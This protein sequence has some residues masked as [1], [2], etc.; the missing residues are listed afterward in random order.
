[1]ASP[2]DEILIYK[3]RTRLK[4]FEGKCC[5]KITDGTSIED[6][7]ESTKFK[8]LNPPYSGDT[9]TPSEIANSWLG[10]FHF[11]EDIPE[12]NQMGL[13]KPQLGALHSISSYFSTTQS[14]EPGTIVLPTGTGKTE[15]MLATL[16]YQRCDK[17][18][19]LVP[20]NVL[21]DQI[22]NKFIS[23]GY[24]HEL[25]VIDYMTN[26]PS[27]CKITK[28]IQSN[29]TIKAIVENSNVIVATASILKSS[30]PIVVDQLCKTCSHL[31]VDEAH[32]IS[33]KTWSEIKDRFSGKKIVQ[34]TATPFRNDGKALGGKIIYNY[35]MSEAQA[36]NYFKPINM[37]SIEEFNDAEVDRTI[38]ET[39]V[40]KLREDIQ[41]EYDHLLLA[42]VKSTERAEEVYKIYNKIAPDLHPTIVHS[43]LRKPIVRENIQKL[44][45]FE[46]KIIVCVDMLGEGF[47]LPNL[48]IAAI[49][50]HHKSLS[51]T[52][53][54]IGRFTRSD[55][56]QNIDEAS[57]I[58]N[59]ADPGVENELNLLYSQGADWDIVLRRLSDKRIQKE[60]RLQEIINSL[61]AEGDLHKTI[62][63]WNIKP[64]LSAMLFQTQCENW[65]PNN[66]V[67]SLP[68]F[69]EHW[70]AISQD[71]NLLIVLGISSTKVK[72][73]NYEDLKDINYKLLVAYWNRDYNA[74]NIFSNDYNAFRAVSMSSSLCGE[75]TTIY[76]GEQ[77][78]N[79]FN[80]IEYPLVR[81]LGASQFGAISFTQFFGPNV[82]DGLSRIAQS[83][84]NL[85]NI[86][87]IGYENG[88][89]V[90]WGC[91]EKRGKIWS[92]QSCDSI[93]DWCEWVDY[94]WKKISLGGI[95][96][97]NIT[98]DFLKPVKITS[99]HT[100]YPTSV[101]W[102]EYLLSSYEDKVKIIFKDVEIPFYLVELSLIHPVEPDSIKFKISSGD[103]E[104][105]YEFK[106][107]ERSPYYEY[108][109][110][111][112]SPVLITKG[113]KE[114]IDF[115]DYMN[116]DPI[117]F[118]YIDGAFSYNCFLIKINEIIGLF[119]SDDLEVED[120]SSINI[121]KESMGKDRI[122]NTVQYQSYSRIKNSYDIIINDDGSGE[123]ADLVGIKIT[124][125]EIVLE[126]VHCKYSSESAPGAR[127]SDFYEVCGQAQRSIRWKHIG[128]VGLY[129][130]LKHRESL[131]KKSGYTRFLK[132]T[133]SDLTNI[134][135]RSRKTPIRF[136]V[137]IVQPGLSAVQVNN[138]ILRLLGSTA[139]YIKKTTE[140]DLSVIVSK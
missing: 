33:A 82:T 65:N 121:R 18:L 43:N 66:Y 74:L 103:I 109:L 53:Q 134:K 17:V 125:N 49:H 119:P 39:A 108:S 83:E 70:H 140:A 60:V 97:E 88:Q 89:K 6:I 37:I 93:S 30:D 95:D 123:T 116:I 126:L 44:L 54:F 13:R 139:Q 25:N 105:I 111:E 29:G 98:R 78:F 127:L 57:V 104:S 4:D 107:L 124:E 56:K 28:G 110:L 42:R 73:G 68:S 106:I 90:L 55:R 19:V 100:S 35:S 3:P 101:H 8:W 31:F 86:A 5:L 26:F 136:K 50:D 22:T 16:V 115:I 7:S 76:S 38:A 112:G 130:R 113:K 40:T 15:T 138:E 62:S 46:S 122:H 77:I 71:E 23:L 135:N 48:K 41:N 10:H 51:I 2:F 20:S 131:W 129:K 128:F 34:F 118:N 87:T 24:L 114:A 117:Y 52:L 133:M 81:N 72:W 91:S 92:P 63:L 132:G 47:D 61:K 21:R 84:L 137:T 32:H 9:L 64:S 14:V 67:Q 27:V 80:N 94:A 45:S 75:E 79:I 11:V 120:W 36:A 58:I 12:I 1:L 85:S 59:I 96:E 69:D 99:K 102:G